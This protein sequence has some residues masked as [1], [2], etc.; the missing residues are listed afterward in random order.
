MVDAAAFRD[1]TLGHQ[2]IAY[3][4]TAAIRTGLLEFAP[5]VVIK[6]GPGT[7]LGG[8]VGQVMTSCGW[9]GL[10]TKSGFARMHRRT[11]AS[12]RWDGRIRERSR[13]VRSGQ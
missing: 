13:P 2:V 11:P 10:C 4:F 3:D 5:E 1:Y 9:W 6:L 8:A 7:T 12:S